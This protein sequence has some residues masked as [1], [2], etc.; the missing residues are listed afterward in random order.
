MIQYGIQRAGRAYTRARDRGRYRGRYRYRDTEYAGSARK[1]KIMKHPPIRHEGRRRVPLLLIYLVGL[2]LVAA[3]LISVTASAVGQSPDYAADNYAAQRESTRTLHELSEGY[4]AL[5]TA[6]GSDRWV[7]VLAAIDQYGDNNIRALFVDDR[8]KTES[9]IEDIRRYEAMGTVAGELTWIY[10]AHIDRLPAAAQAGVTDT[11]RALLADLSSVLHPSQAVLTHTYA[12][13][14]QVARLYAAVYGIKLDALFR[15]G[16]SVAVAAK[17]TAAR[18]ELASDACVPVAAEG[19]VGTSDELYRRVLEQTTRAVAV[20][21][22][23]EA[24]MAQLQAVFAILYPNGVAAEHAGMVGALGALDDDS[25]DTLAVLHRRLG[26]AVDRLLDEQGAAP[27]SH[28]DRYLATL[29]EGV[30]A[31]LADANTA[32][33]VAD[34]RPVFDGYAIRSIRAGAKDS[35]EGYVA[36]KGLSED[37]A[38][39]ELLA[40]YTRTWGILDGC[41]TAEEVAFESLRATLLMDLCAAYRYAESL[42][43]AYGGEAQEITASLSAVTSAYE[44]AVTLIAA[45]HPMTPTEDKCRGYYRDCLTVF[46]NRTAD[47]EVK[48]FLNRHDAI[49]RHPA[50]SVSAADKG[51]LL[52]ALRDLMAMNP[53]AKDKFAEAHAPRLSDL[54]DKYRSVVGAVLTERLPADTPMGGYAAQLVELLADEAPAAAH[55]S[56]LPAWMSVM[57]GYLQKA[58]GITAIYD[59]YENIC[60]DNDYSTY[61]APDRAALQAAVER[62]AAALVS[63]VGDPTGDPPLTELLTATTAEGLASL[64]R[65]EAYAR[66]HVKAAERKVS[67]EATAA[68]VQ[69]IVATAKTAMEAEHEALAIRDL[70]ERALL[71]MARAYAAEDM[72]A[73]GD[74][75]KNKM[76]EK[77]FLPDDERDAW[78]DRITACLPTAVDTLWEVADVA[79]LEAV[80]AQHAEALNDL[81]EAAE[82]ANRAAEATQK[83]AGRAQIDEVKR[84]ALA[85]VQSGRFLSASARAELV[86]RV[87][88]LAQAAASQLEAAG[89]TEAYLSA[90]RALEDRLRNLCTEVAADDAASAQSRRD[91]AT[92]AVG[93]VHRALMTALDSMTY[94]TEDRRNEDK[95]LADDEVRA[96]ES[97][98]TAA[99]TPDEI[100]AAQERAETALAVLHG[101]ASHDNM[102]EEGDVVLTFLMAERDKLLSLIDSRRYLA[103]SDREALE[104]EVQAVYRCAYEGIEA[105]T[106]APAVQVTK[107]EAL[108]AMNALS[109]R[110]RAVD[111]ERCLSVLTPVL[112]VLALLAAAE[113]AAMATLSVCRRRRL[114]MVCSAALVPV[115]AFPPASI[116]LTPLV[117]W[118]LVWLLV[119]LDVLLA[120]GIVW[121]AVQLLKRHTEGSVEWLEGVRILDGPASRERLPS[122]HRASAA[123]G[124]ERLAGA[125][126]MYLMPPAAVMPRVVE[127]V[128]AEEADALISDEDA[129]HCVGSDLEDTEVY[130]GSKKAEIN[131][132]VIARYFKGGETVTLNSLKKKGLLPR[133][134]GYVK[135][136]ARG[137]LDKSL[138]VIAQGFS[139]SAVKMIVLTGG[140]AVLTEGAVERWTR[141]R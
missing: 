99:T 92:E 119:A 112:I 134:V 73:A 80:K 68:I 4:K 94:L 127:A 34:L 24:A 31:V 87:E 36:D 63:R 77:G 117:A 32:G 35:L 9:L 57:E 46:H 136:L 113:I 1:E 128:T 26:E 61:A 84:A 38:M 105:A 108:A 138:T 97:A 23:Q 75:A 135:I 130:R 20:Q 13:G 17:V 81:M 137:R 30:A 51:A 101:R 21:R 12:Q 40:R 11:Y 37:A 41:T 48:A 3:T 10:Y 6:S 129:L 132:D 86:A 15:E 104:N 78:V 141:K 122:P 125:K 109:Q 102:L 27:G 18:V 107:G 100:V 50:D 25:V 29:R 19:Q 43:S 88:E 74:R 114:V 5:A 76:A 116:T 49:L 55:P 133:S 95:V 8:Y 103:D 98:L 118:G 123:E 110:I 58:D 91:E 72:T 54:T 83:T 131:M 59:L 64:Y 44:D 124:R 111:D 47:A 66:L 42:I 39:G 89:T 2:L 71:D 85:D 126:L 67:T 115:T 56:A 69:A 65:A 79:A 22:N 140:R 120:T 52:A 62:A 70:T 93:A 33:A 60:A 106:E 96:F 121:L 82:A 90:V 16:D 7:E 139:A 28:T 14:G 53:M 45:N